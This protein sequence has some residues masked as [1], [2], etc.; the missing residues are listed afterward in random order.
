MRVIQILNLAAR[1]R[2]SYFN[3]PSFGFLIYRREK[4]F[5]GMGNIKGAKFPG[6]L[7]ILNTYSFC[8]LVYR[9]ICLD[10]HPKGL[11]KEIVFMYSKSKHGHTPLNISISF[12]NALKV[13]I[14]EILEEGRFQWGIRRLSP[15]FLS[16]SLSLSFWKYGHSLKTWLIPRTPNIVVMV[17]P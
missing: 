16:L 13:N 5:Q 1:L 12:P 11:W 17:S 15:S 3:S 4:N 6:H 2:G 14:E 7:K 9:L 10:C 8:F